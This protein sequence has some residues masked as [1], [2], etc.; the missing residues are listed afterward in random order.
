MPIR[1]NTYTKIISLLVLLLIPII[2]LYALSNQVSVNVLIGEIRELN[3]KDM[4]FLAN[5]VNSSVENL[6]TMAFLLT[7]D[8][9][10]QQLQHIHLMENAYERNEQKFR[11]LERLRLLNVAE[12]W[13]RSTRS[14]PRKSA[15][16]CRPIIRFPS[17]WTN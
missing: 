8:I 6:S 5:E 13:D 4:Q 11:I 12:R 15:K 10:I 16:W 3:Q 17:I 14:W 1:Y 2:I 9:H 7:E